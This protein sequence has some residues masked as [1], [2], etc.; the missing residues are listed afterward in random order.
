MAAATQD[1]FGERQPSELVPYSGASGFT[2]YKDTLQ[3]YSA[4]GTGIRPLVQGV[5]ASNARFIGVADNRVDLSSGLGASQE[6]LN[7]FKKGE[8]TFEAQGTGVSAHIGQI[9]YGLDDQTVGVSAAAPA[10]PVGEIV[11]FPTA[12]TYRIR[13]DNAINGMPHNR[14]VSWAQVQN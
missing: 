6:T 13:I 8:Y 1:R 10:L 4:L 3:M 2:Y 5:G 7:V 12:S 14:G 11:G 9:A